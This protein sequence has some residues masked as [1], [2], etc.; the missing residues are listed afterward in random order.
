[1]SFSSSPYTDEGRTMVTGSRAACALT[2]SSAFFLEV[3]YHEIGLGSIVSL[4]GVASLF[5]PTA[6]WLDTYK[7]RFRL[8]AEYFSAASSMLMVPCV[9]VSSKSCCVGTNNFAPR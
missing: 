2:A 1:M 7:N 8:P 4:Y 3:P 6:A 5:G 9:L